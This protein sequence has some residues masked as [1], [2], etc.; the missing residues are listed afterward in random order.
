MDVGAITCLGIVITTFL[1]LLAILGMMV[2]VV[3]IR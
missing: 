2:Y 1:V 3:F